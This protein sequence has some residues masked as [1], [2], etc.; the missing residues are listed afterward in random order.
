MA[1]QVAGSV[2][3]SILGVLSGLICVCCGCKWYIKKRR[4]AA[5][6]AVN[7]GLDGEEL[8]FKRRMDQIQG[9][10]IDELFNFSGQEDLA[11]DDA[12]LGQIAMLDHYRNNL[13]A[14]SEGAVT[15]PMPESAEISDRET[16]NP[17][18]PINLQQEIRDR[19]NGSQHE[20]SS[21]TQEVDE[22]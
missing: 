19:E 3:L 5:Y 15:P 18:P 6:H 9:G 12:E 21:D 20:S 1:I 16:G 13:V 2:I 8:A 4:G 10:E 7:H 14:G 17:A 22:L 11:F